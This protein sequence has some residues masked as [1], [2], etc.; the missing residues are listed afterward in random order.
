MICARRPPPT[1]SGTAQVGQTLSAG[2]TGAFTGQDLTYSYQWQDSTDGSTWHDI[3]NNATNVTY[4]PV[5]GDVDDTIEVVVTATNAGGSSSSTSQPTA[6]I[7]LPAAPGAPVI[8]GSPN[9]TTT[10]TTATIVWAGADGGT[11]E[12][13]L[14]GGAFEPCVSPLQLTGLT[15]GAHTLA[16]RQLND[17]GVAS[18]AA[19]VRWTVNTA[20]IT[21]PSGPP[22]DARARVAL[23]PVAIAT[24]SAASH[25]RATTI[26]CTL[27]KAMI[28]SCTTTLTA[29]IAG[30]R[31]LIGHGTATA[32]GDGAQRIAVTSQLTATALR[33]AD[34]PGG[35]KIDVNATI[36][37]ASTSGELYASGSTRLVLPQILVVP[38]DGMFASRSAIIQASSM[39]SSATCAQRL[40]AS[41]Q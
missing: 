6:V 24:S 29:Q 14:D 10:A 12:C 18:P 31:V 11:F 25:A 30:R 41:A 17:A 35:L 20:P 32:G 1:I 28:R 19:T 7:A 37:V 4:T 33:L 5:A 26:G 39:P 40:P 21:P 36:T 22:T 2:T 23:A 38:D 27:T 8:Q 13:S 15:A 3:A 9:S 16:I 34:R